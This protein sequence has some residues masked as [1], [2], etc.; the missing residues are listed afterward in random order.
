[1]NLGT[2]GDKLPLI[3]FGSFSIIGGL[4]A[5]PL[6][7]TRHNPLPESIDDV[8]HYAEFC[9]EARRQSAMSG[10]VAAAGSSE[11]STEMQPLRNGNAREVIL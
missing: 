9:K 1:M 8:E 7:E 4:L 11:N 5:L 3:I 6:P 2:H 10:G